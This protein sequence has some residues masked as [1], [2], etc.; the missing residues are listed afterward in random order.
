VPTGA[1]SETAAFFTTAIE[2][3]WVSVTEYPSA[4]SIVTLF[5]ED[6]TEP[7]NVTVPAAGASTVEPGSPPTSRPRCCPPAYGWFGSKTKGWR[8]A[9]PDGHVQAPATGASRSAASTAATRA[10]RIDTTFVV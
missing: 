6:G 2:P 4:V 5:P 3:R 1:P 8:T 9:P 7:A 10:R